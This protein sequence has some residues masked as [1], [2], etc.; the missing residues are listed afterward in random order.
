MGFGTTDQNDEDLL[1]I[2]ARASLAV[3]RFCSVPMVPQRYSFRG[4]SVS[5]EDHTF[6][7]GNG[8]NESPTRV[9]WPRSTPVKSVTQ[10][11]VYV[12]NT[13]YVEFDAAELFVTK[14]NINITSLSLTSIGLFGAFTVPVIGLTTP[15]CR[16][17]Y[18]YG[19]DFEATEEVLALTEGKTYRAQNQFWD[20]TTV[21]VKKDGVVQSSGYTVDKTEGTVTF[22]DQFPDGTVVTATYGYTLPAEV[23]Q[24]TGLTVAKFIADMEMTQ[25][26]M[27]NLQELRV[28]EISMTRPSP[29]AMASNHSIDLPN[30]AKQ[31]LA[32]LHFMTIR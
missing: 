16:V 24:A 19:Y 2:I 15:I 4:G 28:G 1:S 3:D 8:V 31:L 17:S 29:R 7:L 23:P 26:G 21:V 20:D 22:T 13:Q 10:M 12:T 6:Y 27:T 11:R 30:E 18:T 14:A 5:D 25:R 32:G 9:I